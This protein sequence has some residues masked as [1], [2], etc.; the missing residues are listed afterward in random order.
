MQD[1]ILYPSISERSL[2]LW[3]IVSITVSCLIAEWVVLSFLKQHRWLVVVPLVLA[4]A[5]MYL[6]HKAYA[7]NLRSLGFRIDNFIAALRLLLGPTILA[8]AIILIVGW[9][10]AGP[11]SAA[12]LLRPRLLLLP[13]WAL[14]QQYALQAFMNRRAQLAVGQGY[15]SIVLVAVVFSILHLPNL[16]LSGLT[17]MGGLIWGAVYQRQANLYALAASHTVAS[18][19]LVAALPLSV[20]N[21][22]R[23][24]FKYFG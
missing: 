9:F 2:A 4:I 20:I 21:G 23:V 19:S 7:E 13:F 8:V 5:L 24:G 17:L 12:R 14:L 10:L 18:L 22:L 6:S 16:A 11:P 15:K 3:E 1:D